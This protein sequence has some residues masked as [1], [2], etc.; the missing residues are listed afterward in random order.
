MY[1]FHAPEGAVLRNKLVIV[2][3]IVIVI[4]TTCTMRRKRKSDWWY[5]FTCFIQWLHL[6]VRRKNKSTIHIQST[7]IMKFY[8]DSKLPKEKVGLYDITFEVARSIYSTIEYIFQCLLHDDA[9]F[10]TMNNTWKLKV[11]KISTWCVILLKRAKRVKRPQISTLAIFRVLVLGAY[12]QTS[13]KKQHWMTQTCLCLTHSLLETHSL[14]H[15]Y[16]S[17]TVVRGLT[18]DM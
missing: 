4:Q 11:T 9:E 2:I 14:V 10:S 6:Q 1:F 16:L 13:F 7:W 18:Y 5:I 17:M 3:V 8:S 12:H 15:A